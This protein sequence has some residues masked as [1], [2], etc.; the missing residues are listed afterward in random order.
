MAVWKRKVAGVWVAQDTTGTDLAGYVAKADYDANTILAATTDNTPVALPVAA[1]RVL[2]R[3][4]TGDIDDMTLAEVVALGGTPDGTKFLRDD[5]TLA[6]P[7]GTP[8]GRTILDQASNSDLTTT[9]T[10]LVAVIGT[11]ALDVTF[12]VPASGAVTVVLTAGHYGSEPYWSLT[13][14]GVAVTR[15]TGIRVGTP[16]GGV[17]HRT[18]RI[19]V[20]GLTPGAAK[21]WKWVHRVAA[22]SSSIRYGGDQGAAFMEVLAA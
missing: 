16:G 12:T 20:S 10:T 15:T 19:P 9:S 13:D 5:G 1:S 2:G 21:T 11:S 4:A 8:I 7:P 22:G 18:V 3:K 6:V 17:E 14:A